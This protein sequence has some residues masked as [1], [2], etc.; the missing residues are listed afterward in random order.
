MATGEMA[1][2]EMD[3]THYSTILRGTLHFNPKFSHEQSIP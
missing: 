2:G 1:T 3:N